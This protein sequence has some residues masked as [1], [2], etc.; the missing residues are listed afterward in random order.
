MLDRVQRHFSFV[1]GNLAIL[2]GSWFV[3]MFTMRIAR[4]YRS[5]YIVEALGGTATIVGLITT[6][7]AC[8]RTLV[9]IPGGY[10]AD[11][12]GRKKIIVVMTFI[13][14][15]TYLFYIF[16]FDWT[17]ILIGSAISSLSLVYQPALRA[18]TADSIPPEKRGMGY[19]LT[20]LLPGIP[21]IIAPYLGG[22]LIS[23][24]GLDSGM[25]M[26]YSLVFVGGL[27]AT[28]LRFFL[29]ETL[30]NQSESIED[31]L[32]RVFTG[33]LRK[34]F[35]SLRKSLSL[36]G[37]A[38]CAS[39]IRI[40][41]FAAIIPFCILYAQLLGVSDEEWGLLLTI[42]MAVTVA[43]SMIIGRLVDKYGRRKVLLPFF[44]SLVISS[45][46]FALS[47]NF[48]H[49]LI[50]YAVM[51]TA[52][53]ASRLA[54]NALQADLI[55]KRDRGRVLGGIDLISSA[56]TIPAGIMMGLGWDQISHM[57]P[58]LTVTLLSLIGTLVLAL[59]VKDPEK[60]R[61]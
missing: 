19:A 51:T 47:S 36:T 60:R 28:L 20:R 9:R 6:V 31:D 4:P 40:C 46:G 43:S 14:T 45:L 52:R 30:K 56:V 27:I 7:R 53:S 35:R 16:A 59:L 34:T 10:I 13:V 50:T 15:F 1:K 26:A 25:R 33:T 39:I 37:V 8:T 58:F 17:W 2:L 32:K 24:Y 55:P 54:I 61:L 18:I 49:L 12:W 29:R 5:R 57:F 11:R 22:L 21:G 3:W 48:L 23:W 38:V 41:F 44:I 42:S